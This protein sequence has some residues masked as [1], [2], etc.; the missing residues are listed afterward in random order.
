MHGFR[1]NASSFKG[2]TASLAKK[3]KKIADLV[4]IDAPHELPYIYQPPLSGHNANCVSSSLP[5]S[6]PPP[7]ENCKKKFAWF[8]APNFDGGS[9]ADWKVADGPFDPLQYQQQT[10]GYDISLAHLKAV[11]SQEGPFD[12]I[13]GFSQ[14]AAMAALISSQQEKLKGEMDFRFVIL[15]SGFVI[16]IKEME[17]GLIKCP[18]L[19]IFGDDDH[20]KDRQIAN[21]ASKELASLYDGGCSVIVEHDSGHIIPTRSPYIDQIKDFLKR[22]L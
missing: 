4:F 16:H 17:C 20:G 22:F 1:Q 11:F 13:L 5:P 8:V 6:P 21:L 10:D 3:L 14:G 2:R 9:R 7:M 12:G 19:H 15:C 18:S